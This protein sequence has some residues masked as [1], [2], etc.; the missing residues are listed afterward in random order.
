MLQKS[1]D[2]NHMKFKEPNAIF[3][4]PGPEELQ[5]NNTGWGLFG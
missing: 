2:R 4:A 1:A 3:L 5:G